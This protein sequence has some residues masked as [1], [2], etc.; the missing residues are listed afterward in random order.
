MRRLWKAAVLAAAVAACMSVTAFADGW[1]KEN[2]QW[3]YYENGSKVMNQWRTSDEGGYYFLDNFGNMLVNSFIDD[4]RYVDADGHMVTDTWRQID[5]RWYYFDTNGHMIRNK[6]KQINGMY[7]YFGPE[8]YMQTGW[9][10]DD[11]GTWYYC[12]PSDGHRVTASWKQLEPAEE[13][14]AYDRDDSAAMQDGKYWYYFQSNGKMCCADSS[15]YKEF[16]IDGSRFAFD[17]YG[18]LH[19]GWVKLADKYP[20]I[21]GYKYFNDTSEIGTFGAAHVGWLSAYPPEDAG[22]GSE[23]V[24][25]YFD[26][27]GE[28]FHGTDVSEQE[29]DETLGG[30]FKRLVKN[31]RTNTYLFNE[32]GNPVYGLRKVKRTNG[33]VTSMYFGTRQE[34]CLQLGEKNIVEAD[35]TTSVFCFDNSGYGITG[36]KNGKLYYMGKLQKAVD[37][38]YA[39][40]TVNDITWLVNRSGGVAKNH[41][42]SKDPDAVDYRSASAGHRDGGTEKESSLIVPEF[43]ITEL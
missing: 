21:A 3:V 39:Y 11:N 25:Y 4:D 16:N 17:Q 29:N 27:K 9:V 5:G 41:N 10:E 28:P 38:S 26:S 8:G 14:Y 18:R 1:T 31:G 2:N 33:N 40:Y 7:Y 37:D 32:Y 12:D 15:E 35:G 36:I 23:V 20:A 13:M 30:R 22:L 19:T 42:Q 24:W 43:V 6:S 34:C